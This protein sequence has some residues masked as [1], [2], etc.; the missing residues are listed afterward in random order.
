M[1]SALPSVRESPM[2]SAPPG[3]G[4]VVGTGRSDYWV[5]STPSVWRS[6]RLQASIGVEAPRDSGNG[7][8]ESDIPAFLRR[9]ADEPGAGSDPI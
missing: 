3:K 7:A 6:A 2:L 9:Q 1:R 8:D 4:R 5:L